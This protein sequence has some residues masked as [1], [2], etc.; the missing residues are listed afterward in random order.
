MAERQYKIRP[1]IGVARVGD[2]LRS[3]TSQQFYFIG[4]EFPEIAANVEP[5]SN[6][7]AEFKMPDGRVKSQAA[8]FRVFEYE[9][10]DDGKFHP[11]GEVTIRDTTRHV[12]LT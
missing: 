10:K 11:I 8:R 4:P 12:T 5:L 6:T 3:D 9:K 2:A 1:A 7:Q